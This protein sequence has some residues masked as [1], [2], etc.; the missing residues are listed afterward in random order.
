[1]THWS[2]DEWVRG[3]GDKEPKEKVR[4]QAKDFPDLVRYLFS[5][6]PTFRGYQMS[7]IR[8]STRG[9]GPQGY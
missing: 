3:S 2:W 9:R 5:D 7:G 4:D 6:H 1:M 8:H